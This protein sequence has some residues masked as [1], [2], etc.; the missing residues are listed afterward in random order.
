VA[1]TK[2]R[3]KSHATFRADSRWEV[4]SHPSIT[5]RPSHRDYPDIVRRGFGEDTPPPLT[6]SRSLDWKKRVVAI[7]GSR[8]A[9]PEAA[10]CA[11]AI[12]KRLASS[13]IVVASG[14]A[15]GIDKAAHD[16]ALAANGE[17]WCIAPTSPDFVWPE[18]HETLFERIGKSAGAMIWPFEAMRKPTYAQF[19]FRNRVLAAL[20]EAVIVVQA[21]LRSGSLNTARAALDMQ[22][23]LF[24]LRAPAWGGELFDG[25]RA[26]ATAHRIARTIDDV[27][28]LYVELGIAK[29]SPP[30]PAQL[31]L[32]LE[33]DPPA[34][35]LLE[36]VTQ[37]PQHLD[38]IAHS[39][40]LPVAEAATLLLT[41]ALENVVVEG[42]SGFYRRA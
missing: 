11:R 42:P 15:E 8:N 37:S 24:I 33:L 4:V 29:P 5:L 41:L 30:R 14:G 17:T 12:A 28:H 34:R 39:C 3:T 6:T 2:S 27:K 1:S 32:T 23:K 22:K 21:K 31:A 35:K 40:G 16:G 7:V 9:T 18:G 19:F 13:G 26:F 20:S 36:A 25:N 10:T 38:E